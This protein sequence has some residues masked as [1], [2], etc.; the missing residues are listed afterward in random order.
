[1]TNLL[2]HKIIVRCRYDEELS[3]YLTI[4]VSSA[5]CFDVIRDSWGRLTSYLYT[6]LDAK[7]TLDRFI[8]P[9]SFSGL[10]MFCFNVS[11]QMCLSKKFQMYNYGSASKNM[12]HYGQVSRRRNQMASVWNCVEYRFRSSAIPIIREP[13]PLRNHFNSQLLLL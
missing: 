13:Y 4:D 6:V 1:M 9:L 11:Q 10:S 3:Y 12:E 5:S 2:S 8:S 7:I